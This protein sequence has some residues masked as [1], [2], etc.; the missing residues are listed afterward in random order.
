M[1]YDNA[2]QFNLNFLNY[3]I[4]GIRTS[5]KAPN[6]N[7]VAERFVGSIRRETLDYY[8]F[9]SEK[10][11]MKLLREYSDCYNSKHPL[12]ELIKIFLWDIYL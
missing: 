9:I 1:I 5:V 11:I 4:K 6:M 2:V 8:L 7:T 12:K 10:Q 3:G